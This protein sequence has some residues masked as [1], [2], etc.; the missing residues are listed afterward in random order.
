MNYAI[1]KVISNEADPQPVT[2]VKPCKDNW[3]MNI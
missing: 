3:I 2:C 1:E